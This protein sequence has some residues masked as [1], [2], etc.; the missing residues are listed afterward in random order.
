MGMA[1][2]QPLPRAWLVTD[3]RQGDR[4]LPAVERLPFGS[5]ILFRHYSLPPD[6]RRELFLEIRGVARRRGHLLLLSGSA[7]LSK[8]WGADGWHGWG[9]GAGLH[10]VSVHSRAEIRAAE[11]AGAALL[12]LAPVFPTRSHPGAEGLGLAAFAH[13]AHRTELPVIALGGVS[14]EHAGKVMGLGAYG[15]AAVDAWTRES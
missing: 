10:S 11:R 7:A 2:R 12:F 4:L 6:G 13:L 3:E 8:R 14:R 1:P 9:R 5:G 15:W